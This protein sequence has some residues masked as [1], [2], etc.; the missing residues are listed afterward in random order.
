MINNQAIDTHK[1]LVE[2]SVI[3]L[4]G[5]HH[6]NDEIPFA[7]DMLKNADLSYE[8]AHNTI[9]VEGDWNKI[10][11]FIYSCYDRVQSQFPQGFLK[12][13]IR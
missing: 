11:E 12:V 13:S 8:Q 6:T 7:L 4:N 3:P 9:C 1:V 5:N 2:L 10:S